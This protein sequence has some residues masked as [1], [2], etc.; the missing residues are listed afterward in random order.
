LLTIIAGHDNNDPT[1]SALAVPDY[2]ACIDY[3][4]DK[5]RIGIAHSSYFEGVEGDVDN[6]L[7]S[8]AQTL[9]ATGAEVVSVDLPDPSVAFELAEII[10]K[11]EAAA[12]HEPWLRERP[13][14]YSIAI[15]SVI[16]AGLFIPAVHYLQ[17]VRL[18]AKLLDEFCREVF[19][20]VDVVLLP[21]TPMAA[22]LLRDCDPNST[23]GAAQTMAQF[24]RFTRPFSY[25]GLPVLCVPG[26]FS[27][28]GMP[29]SFQ[30][31]GAPFEESLLL[32][33]GHRYQQETNW[34]RCTPPLQFVP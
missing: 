5:R 4:I 6:V 18:R 17:A 32:N 22:P 20:K 15:R 2:E 12:L 25:L 24:P 33:I 14:D 16:E 7:Q 31:V 26:G 13:G 34:H 8:V 30:L 10:V 11:S 19:S 1:S 21:A 27:K 28:Q 23:F 3:P 29:I 9:K